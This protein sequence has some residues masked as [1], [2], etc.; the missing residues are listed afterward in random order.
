MHHLTYLT[1]VLR[2]FALRRWNNSYIRSHGRMWRKTHISSLLFQCFI[3]N[4][5]QLFKNYMQITYISMSDFPLMN[6]TILSLSYSLITWK[7]WDRKHWSMVEHWVV[8]LLQLTSTRV[9]T[10]D[11]ES[12]DWFICLIGNQLIKTKVNMY[13]SCCELSIGQRKTSITVV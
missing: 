13:N 11:C 4:A 6:I 10:Y 9:N 7:C 5:R 12:A 8:V 3:L 2:I 1:D